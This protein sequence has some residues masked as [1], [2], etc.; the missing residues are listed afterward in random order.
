MKLYRAMIS[1]AGGPGEAVCD[2]TPDKGLA[3]DYGITEA[4]RWGRA[5]WWIEEQE[6]DVL[7]EVDDYE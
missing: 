1:I 2:W 7:A 6:S 4:Y 3:N 5:E